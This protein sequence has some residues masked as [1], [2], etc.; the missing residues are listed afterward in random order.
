MFSYPT[1]TIFVSII[2]I[3]I[4]H[5]AR[6]EIHICIEAAELISGSLHQVIR[7]TRS[8][9]TVESHPYLAFSVVKSFLALFFCLAWRWEALNMKMNYTWLYNSLMAFA[10]SECVAPDVSFHRR[11]CI[12]ATCLRFLWSNDPHRSP[13]P[14]SFQLFLSYIFSPVTIHQ[15]GMTVMFPTSL[16]GTSFVLHCQVRGDVFNVSEDRPSRFRSRSPFRA[17][18]PR[19]ASLITND[20]A[21]RSWRGYAHRVFNR[22]TILELLWTKCSGNRQRLIR[23]G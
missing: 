12:C 10:V 20:F 19:V 2:M 4:G 16:P 6:N 14:R 22:Q 13:C 21:R 1:F 3:R 18:R 23:I 8:A 5:F 9:S 17:E 7:Q 11:G 15:L